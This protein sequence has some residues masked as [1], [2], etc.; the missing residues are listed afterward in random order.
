MLQ[1]DGCCARARRVPRQI[2]QAWRAAT[3]GVPN[4]FPN[5]HR[6]GDPG[7]SRERCAVAGTSCARSAV[8]HALY[9]GAHEEMLDLVYAKPTVS[10]GMVTRSMQ[11]EDEEES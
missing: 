6:G 7:R 5:A 3:V 9:E 4:L 11:L 2:S 8:T 1:Q 10:P